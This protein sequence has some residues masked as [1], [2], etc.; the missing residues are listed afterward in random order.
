MTSAEIHMTNPLPPDLELVVQELLLLR[1]PK[2]FGKVAL[3]IENGRIFRLT[4]E[5]SVVIKDRL[6]EKKPS[7]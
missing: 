7:G 2:W 1:D 5:E 6:R 4:K 3:Y